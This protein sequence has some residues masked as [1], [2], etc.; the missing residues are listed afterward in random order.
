MF[1][2]MKTFYNGL[3][4]ER[5]AVFMYEMRGIFSKMRTQHNLIC[6]LSA[7]LVLTTGLLI[8]TVI[9]DKVKEEYRKNKEEGES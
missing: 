9:K 7:G 8:K 3:D 1:M 4:D 2:D 5:K 6:V